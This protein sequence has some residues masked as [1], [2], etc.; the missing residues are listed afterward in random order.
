MPQAVEVI[1]ATAIARV[2]GVTA[3]KGSGFRYRAAVVK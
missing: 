2:L 1:R 3:Y